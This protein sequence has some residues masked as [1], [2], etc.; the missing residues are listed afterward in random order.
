MEPMNRDTDYSIRVIT[1][2]EL[3]RQLA[4]G[5]LRR[6]RKPTRRSWAG[7]QTKSAVSR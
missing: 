3:I 1:R 6:G 7:A 2:E 5:C 4:E